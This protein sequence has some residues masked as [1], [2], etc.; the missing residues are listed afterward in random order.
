MHRYGGNDRAPIW[1]DVPAV[2]SRS[3]LVSPSPSAQN[4]LHLCET[5]FAQECRI[6]LGGKF[7]VDETAHRQAPRQ[8]VAHD[9]GQPVGAVAFP[10]PLYGAMRPQTGSE[11]DIIGPSSRRPPA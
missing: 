1:P 2:A 9:G 10:T 7:V 11:D 6:V 4:G 5:D 8:D 3:R